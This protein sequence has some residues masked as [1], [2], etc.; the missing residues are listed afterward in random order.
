MARLALRGEEDVL[1]V[2]DDE[3]GRGQV[4]APGKWLDR[5]EQQAMA[6]VVRYLSLFA[7]PWYSEVFRRRDG[8]QPRFL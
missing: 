3:D 2:I 5:F 6:C 7:V 8:G 1:L 4:A